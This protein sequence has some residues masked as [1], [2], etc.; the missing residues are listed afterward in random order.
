MK[1]HQA[2]KRLLFQ[3][4]SIKKKKSRLNI[5][6]EHI[7]YDIVAAFEDTCNKHTKISFIF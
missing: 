3:K 1:L 5:H 4:L 6:L 2:N 7:L